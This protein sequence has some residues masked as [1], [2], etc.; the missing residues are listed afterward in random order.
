MIDGKGI[1]FEYGESIQV[2][3]AS[4]HS[5]KIEKFKKIDA[6]S[7]KEVGFCYEC[8]AI[9]LGISQYGDTAEEAVLQVRRVCGIV[10]E[11]CLHRIEQVD[12]LKDKIDEELINSFFDF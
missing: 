12:N 2:V 10:K 7:K 5:F 8:T 6:K 3:E 11:T 4:N 9:P 1:D